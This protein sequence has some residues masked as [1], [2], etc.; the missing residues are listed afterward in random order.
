MEGKEKARPN[1]Y[2]Y[3]CMGKNS[4]MPNNSSRELREP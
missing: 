3:P 1:N 4:A 2:S